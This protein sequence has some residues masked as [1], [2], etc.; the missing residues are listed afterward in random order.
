MNRPTVIINCAM[1]VD[2]KIASSTGKQVR[3]SSDE[4]MKRVYNLRNSVDAVLVG[5]NTVLQDNPKL[6]VKEKYVKTPHHPTRIVLD[7]YCQTPENALI[8]NEKAKTFIVKDEK[9]KCTKTYNE[10]VQMLSIPATN[11]RINVKKLLSLLKDQGIRTLLVEGGGTIIW[12]FITD[13]VVDDLY[14]YIGSMIIGGKK[15]P[16][17]AMGEGFEHED[18]FIRLQLIETKRVGDGILLHY[19]PQ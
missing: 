6:T 15:T 2:G 13:D 3:I 4:D 12:H 17:M 8:V 16:T 19:R 5:I 14:V 10:N 11:G 18:R 7:S 9:I 1:S